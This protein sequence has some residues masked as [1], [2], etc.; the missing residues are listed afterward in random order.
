[1]KE[2]NK[3]GFILKS[4]K[5]YLGEVMIVIG[6]G[7]SAYNVF[8]FSSNPYGSY[9]GYAYRVRVDPTQKNCL[10]EVRYYYQ[11]DILI[12][13]AVGVMLIVGGILIIRHK[14]KTV[15]K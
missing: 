1:M 7:L 15:K 10:E 6:T 4:I 11:S 13:I 8:N 9:Y 3:K 14:Q 5:R 12:L 2:K